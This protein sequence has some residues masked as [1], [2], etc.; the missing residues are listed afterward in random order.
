MP[1]TLGIAKGAVM[2][3]EIPSTTPDRTTV[4]RVLRD[5]MVEMRDG[6]SLAT[7]AYLP[8][9]EG[10]VPTILVR[11][12]YGK[13]GDFCGLPALGEFWT[14]KGYAFVAQDVRGTY[15]SGG[16]FDPGHPD[17]EAKDGYDTVEWIA[18]QEWSNSRVALMGESYYSVTTYA[19]ATLPQPALVCIAP[20]DFPIDRY[21]GSYRAGCLKLAAE[22]YWAIWWVA[23]QEHDDP[24]KE[25]PG[26]DA[27]HL[28][29]ADMAAAAGLANHYFD[30]MVGYPIP[31]SRFWEHRCRREEH[32][33]ISIPILHWAGWYD[34][35]LGQQLAD[36]RRYREL[37]HSGGRNYLMIGPWCH[38]GPYG[39]TER[40]GILP[41]E[42]DGTYRWDT[43]QAFFDRYLMGL[44][45]GF[46]E[47]GLVHYFVLGANEW[48]RVDSWPPAGV[49]PQT[50][51]LAGDGSS[52]EGGRLVTALPG[53]EAPDEYAYDPADPVAW[54]VGTDPY[55][56]SFAMG[57]RRAIEVRPDV[58][59]YSSDVLAV[60]LEIVG[61]LHAVL[62]VATDAVDTDFTVALVDVFPDG[63]VN[64][65]QDGIQRMS[66]RSPE[67]GRELL[68]P[69]QVY[70]VRVDMW[71]IAY[72]V[73][74]GHRLRVE[75]SSS[76]F[77]RYDRNL[78]TAE[79]L[80]RGTT[81]VVA[82]QRVFHDPH[83]PSHVVLPVVPGRH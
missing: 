5:V 60:P 62:H 71:S 42:E 37:D 31:G 73:P 21:E 1:S 53:D 43:Y 36:W 2:D 44:D 49:E 14:R 68:A 63:G 64:L 76:D 29:V 69:G 4:D 72:R 80:L 52:A 67:K 8:T 19:A 16:V 20:G 27:W 61:D 7:D 25:L 59:V 58:L 17:S 70:E 3:Y 18:D 78:N 56:F 46:G 51:F 9:A 10:P 32:E 48:H 30:E 77:D 39:P 41:V 40:T 33:A 81:T 23:P 79:S 45:N 24:G 26:V 28:P 47:D 11:L 34:N 38:D 74:A 13:S 82:H 12:C 65:I 6:I 66:L 83:R 22:A 50:W 75:V 15:G 35:Y 57:D 55:E 54:T